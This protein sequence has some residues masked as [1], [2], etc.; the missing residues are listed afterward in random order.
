MLKSTLFSIINVNPTF[1]LQTH[2]HQGCHIHKWVL[3]A[4]IIARKKV[5][6]FSRNDACF[7]DAFLKSRFQLV[8]YLSMWLH[9]WVKNIQFVWIFNSPRAKWI[10]ELISSL[11]IL[12]LSLTPDVWLVDVFVCRWRSFKT[13]AMSG[14]L[15]ISK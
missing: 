13:G 12:T 15:V 6:E 5:I 14:N 2:K 3:N 10:S 11:S 9:Q 4:K 8:H 7:T 1:N